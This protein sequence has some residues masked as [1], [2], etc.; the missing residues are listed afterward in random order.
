L[1]FFALLF[2]CQAKAWGHGIP[3][4]IVVD[5]DMAID[6]IRA[7]TLL[8]N[9]PETR[10]PVIVASDGGSS[11]RMGAG[12][13]ARLLSY[14][15]RTDAEILEGRALDKPAPPWRTWLAGLPV[16]EKASGGVPALE[17]R[18]S[19]EVLASRIQ[20]MDEGVI[21]LCLGPLTNLAD[22]LRTSA[23]LK[24]KITLIVY[25]GGHPDDPAPGWNTQRDPD[26]ARFVYAS[27]IE[28]HD[29]NLP[30]TRFPPFDTALYSAIAKVNTPAAKLLTVIH[31]F[32]PVGKLL[33]ENHFRIWD[34]MTVIYMND[35]SLFRFKPSTRQAHV[36]SLAEFRFDGVRRTYLGLLSPG[37]DFH[38]HP[39]EA[40]VLK[41]FPREP[42][43]FQDDVAP[44]VSKIIARHGLEEWKACLLTNELHRHLGAYSLVGAKM[45]VRAR[46]I[47]DAP[48][49]TLT[50]LSFAGLKPP[51]SC[52]NDGLQVST[53][54]SLGRGAIEVSSTRYEPAAIFSFGNDRLTL[55]LRKEYTSK[56]QDG[57]QAA[58][59]EFG[60]TNKGYFD[61]VRDLSLQYWLNW[62][63]RDLFEEM[64]EP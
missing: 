38:V 59:K 27:G 52:M 56:I 28:I 3:L 49:D 21:Y 12:H 1:C 60:G 43:L 63:R 34:E 26:A 35:P 53:G 41:E 22:A 18:S 45:G 48:F 64:R 24:K 44:L 47:L 39:R 54:A 4:P 15:G 16:P 36:K 62:D 19:R 20:S 13:A 30:E 6:D 57:I 9:S 11:P 31:D 25:F 33:S 29:M 51:L 58:L 17:V 2:L 10:I 46:E 5:T 42:S 23:G 55:K 61:R 32:P 8:L 37:G 50:V 7:L 40:V 14:F